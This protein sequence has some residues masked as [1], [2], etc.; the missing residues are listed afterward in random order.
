[1]SK[2]KQQM[3]VDRFTAETLRLVS[4]RDTI[5]RT[6]QDWKGVAASVLL[7]GVSGSKVHQ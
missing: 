1:M 2:T 7:F 4:R 6:W 3:E 5:R